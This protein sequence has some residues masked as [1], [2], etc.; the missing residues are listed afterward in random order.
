MQCEQLYAIGA[1][2]RIG[3]QEGGS[4]TVVRVDALTLSNGQLSEEIRDVDKGV[5]EAQLVEVEQDEA[6]LADQGLIV[7]E[8][9]VHRSG[10]TV[11]SS[12]WP[13]SR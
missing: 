10:G 2:R 7:P 9:A 5:A 4:R 13:A 12:R 1:D 8:V 3:L 6:L 11:A